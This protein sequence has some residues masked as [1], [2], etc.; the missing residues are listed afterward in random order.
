MLQWIQFDA[1]VAEVEELLF[2]EFYVW[3]HYSGTLDISTE[4][5]Q[6]VHCLS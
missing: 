1:T 6:Y 3:E 2:A 5:Y 4:E